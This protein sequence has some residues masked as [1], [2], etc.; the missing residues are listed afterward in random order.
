[1]ISTNR[2]NDGLKLDQQII[3]DFILSHASNDER[4][5]LM[6]S[7]L[8]IEMLGLLDSGATNTIVGGNGWR[9]LETLPLT[10]DKN[11]VQT[12]TVATGQQCRS[13]GSVNLPLKVRDRVRVVRALVIPELKHTLILGSDFWR[14]MGIVPDLRHGEW[15]FSAEHETVV[16]SIALNTH[17][18]LTAEQANVLHALVERAFAE[19]GEELGCT[20][21]VEHEI[22]TSSA[23][24]KQRYYPVSPVVQK[25]IDVEL[26]KLLEAGVVERSTSPWSSP[27]VLVKKK[28]QSYRFCVDYRKLNAVTERDAYPI[29]YVTATLDKLR[30]AKFLSSLDIKSAYYQVPLAESSRPLTAFTVPNRGLFQFRRLPMGLANSPATWQRLID[31]VLGPDLE[32]HVFVYLDDIVIVTPSFEKHI[33]VLEEVFRRLRSAKLTVSREKCQFCRP[34]LRYLGYVVDSHGLHVDPEKI[35]AILDMP[36]PTCVTEMRRILGLAS[37]YRRFIPNFSTL[38]APLTSLLRKNQKFVWSSSCEEAF[39]ALKDHLIRAP[40]LSCPDFSLPF[41]IQTDASGYGIG[42]VLT[43]QHPDG[44]RVIAYLSRSLLRAERNYT[45]T[46]R[47]CLA[48]LWAIEK[49]RPYVE[50]SH[51]KVITDHYSLVWLNR[52][53]S[54]SGRL[55]RWAVKLQ[56]YDF[57][58]IH[59]K[60]KEHIVP[61]ALSRGVPV[62]DSM[63][64]GVGDPEVGI[65]EGDKWFSKVWRLAQ[66]KPKRFSAWQ[67]R[68]SKLF[69]N[70]KPAYPELAEESDCWREVVPRHRRTTLIRDVHLSLSHVGVYKTYHALAKKY[71][72]PKMRCDVAT[73]VRKCLNCQ[74]NKPEQKPPR[75]LMLSSQL[76]V[77]KPFELMCA[78]LVGPLPRTRA[79][80][81]Y[82]LTVADCFSKFAFFFPL[83][84]AT[85]P[86]ICRIMENNVFLVF[87]SPRAIIVDNGKQFKSKEFGNLMAS[88]KVQIKF[89][90]LYHPQANPSER[91]NRVLKTMLRCYV[92]ENHRDWDLNLGRVG[93][94]VRASQHEVTGF[95]PNFV[96]F[97]REVQ[98]KHSEEVLDQE[99]IVFARN[100]QVLQ[101]RAVGFQRLFEDIRS[102]LKNAYEQSR[103]NYDLRR[104]DDQFQVNQLVWR[105]NHVL[106]DA[107]KYFTAKLAPRYVGPFR[108]SKRLSPW[109]Y[110]LEGKNG[111]AQGVWHAK[112]LKSHPPD[113]AI[114]SH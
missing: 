70:V 113:E 91:V 25:H 48:V 26:N 44:E 84:T 20:D 97:G 11:D 15:K 49:L 50:G 16:E 31:R 71:Y 86:A 57:E 18:E 104:R 10:L 4:P 28:D 79:G 63:D 59:R 60:G 114:G 62:I 39:R 53:Q 1:M 98:I 66:M 46:E 102:R 17:S 34:E 41:Q 32:P 75:G 8:G 103:S 5:Y 64:S 47:E 13:V 42:A 3:L 94:A 55:A 19:M 35:K 6:V 93:Y 88:Y 82:I 68:G 12:C 85:A 81:Q 7:V 21:L 36:P 99:P 67:V 110:E 51:F 90:A 106:S 54:P 107:S 27:I 80:H 29:P 74:A 24:I 89:T 111:E 77:S 109:T 101:R 43:Q 9:L 30:N 33:E 61:D 83:R 23:P 38:T 96:V 45:T 78:D 95:T 37:W 72:W 22:K 73:Y 40:V 14:I 92:S 52:L 112:D 69:K 76:S 105:R 65:D 2:R 108:I 58:I 100:K 87:G 56:Q